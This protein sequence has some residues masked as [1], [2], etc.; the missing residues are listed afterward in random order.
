MG[1]LVE[2]ILLASQLKDLISASAI[3][4]SKMQRIIAR[5]V[6]VRDFQLNIKCCYGWPFV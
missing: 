6:S 4:V 3:E 2:A 1:K 5:I